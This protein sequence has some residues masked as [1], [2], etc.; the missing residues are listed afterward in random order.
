MGAKQYSWDGSDRL[1]R[2]IDAMT[3]PIAYFHDAVG[4]LSQATYADGRVD[5][6]MPDA[7]GNL[8][9]SSDRSDREY[10]PARGCK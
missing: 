2:V 3:G 8:F 10:G 6:R 5:L 9:R 7:V 4:N 1:S